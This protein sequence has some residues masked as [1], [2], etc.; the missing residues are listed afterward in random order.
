MVGCL[1]VL[2][3]LLFFL[4]HVF[5][6][7]FFHFATGTNFLDQV[8]PEL[9]NGLAN[10]PDF[11]GGQAH[12]TCDVLPTAGGVE[13]AMK[14]VELLEQEEKGREVEEEEEEIELAL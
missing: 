13:D 9:K 14:E 11:L 7:L 4:T 3:Y 5:N 12:Y 1:F 8:V 6:F 10:L 2:L